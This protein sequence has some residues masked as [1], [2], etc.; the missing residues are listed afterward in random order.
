MRPAPQPWPP[1]PLA[2]PAAANAR[3]QPILHLTHAQPHALSQPS[4]RAQPRP[5]PARIRQPFGKG[6]LSAPLPGR[7]RPRPPP[8]LRGGARLHTRRRQS[9]PRGRSE[10][11]L[12]RRAHPKPPQRASPRCFVA[13]A[14]VPSAAPRARRCAPLHAKRRAGARAPALRGRVSPR[15][16][17]PGSTAQGDHAL[18]PRRP[19]SRRTPLTVPLAARSHSCSRARGDGPLREPAR[20]AAEMQRRAGSADAAS[21]SQQLGVRGSRVCV[22]IRGA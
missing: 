19:I 9:T 2:A 15:R 17:T 18:L 4:P 13:H 5:A 10:V 22:C 21:S 1:R 20:S 16:V 3:G 14:R 7:A 12:G 6:G 11:M 8:H